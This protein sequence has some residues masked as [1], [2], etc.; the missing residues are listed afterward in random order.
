MASPFGAGPPVGLS[1]QGQDQWYESWFDS[2]TK[3][4]FPVYTG[5]STLYKGKSFSQIYQMIRQ[6]H[7]TSPAATVAG[8]VFILLVTQGFATAVGSGA[9][10]ATQATAATGTGI[11]KTNF[12]VLDIPNF[13]TLLTSVQFWERMGEV[14]LGLI[15]ISVGTVKLAETNKAASSIVQNVPALKYA[16]ML[17]K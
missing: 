7:P 17:V 1:M 8:N 2:H 14:L 3:A 12:N 6:A 10:T 9:T 16:K 4:K 15:L 11:A 5:K 13:L